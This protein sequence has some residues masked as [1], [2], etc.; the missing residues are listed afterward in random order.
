MSFSTIH[1]KDKVCEM[2]IERVIQGMET[3]DGDGVRLTRMI[4]TSELDMIDPFLMLD[5]FDSDDPNAYIGGFPDHPHRGFETVTLMLDGQLRH[6]DSTGGE[7]L[8]GPGDVQW[9]T[10]GRGIIHSEM[11]EQIDGRMRGF[12]LWVNLPSDKKL[13]PAGYQDITEAQISVTSAP[14][15]TVRVIAGQFGSVQGPARTKTPLRLLRFDANPGAEVTLDVEK[16][17]NAF[18]CVY[19]GTLKGSAVSG[20]IES[21]DAPSLAL[22]KGSGTI[23][24]TAGPAG[25]AFF[26]GEGKP[27]GEPVARYGPFVM[28][29]ESELIQA[30]RD[31]QSGRLTD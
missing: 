24:V 1:L 18:F 6:R 14:G 13:S 26:F 9:M 21:V 8:I 31:F 22:L 17:N 23:S 27:I 19:E 25:A 2:H 16:G 15:F 12:Q 10:A 7:G 29:T 30:V 28:N 11:P 4:G 3:M 5:R 20:D